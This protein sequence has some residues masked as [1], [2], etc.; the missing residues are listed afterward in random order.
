MTRA[1]N[2]RAVLGA[3]LATGA[4]IGA[5]ALPAFAALDTSTLSAVDRRI[6]DLWSR[7]AKLKAIVERLSAQFDAACDAAAMDA[8]VALGDRID[9]AI[10]PLTAVEDEIAEHMDASLLALAATILV[11][12]RDD[13]W[14][15]ETRIYEATLAAIRPQLVGAIAEDADR[16]LAED[17]EA[18]A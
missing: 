5:T 1:T 7:R 15:I 10:N 9:D 4:A 3:V 12:I 6:L 8:N 17:E 11:E 16:V 14:H 2:P 18:R 13:D